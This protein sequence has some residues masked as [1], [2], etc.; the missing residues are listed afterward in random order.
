MAHV[1]IPVLRCFLAGPESASHEAQRD[2]VIRRT[3]TVKLKMNI[4]PEPQTKKPTQ[5]LL[6]IQKWG[7]GGTKNHSAAVQK[8]VFLGGGGTNRLP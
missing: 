6:K 2:L 3:P 1:R 5:W 7:G 4:E 8:A